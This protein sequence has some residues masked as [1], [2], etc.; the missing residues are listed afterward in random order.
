[1]YHGAEDY[2]FSSQ[3]E[4]TKITGITSARVPAWCLNVVRIYKIG[5]FVTRLA[6]PAS[7]QGS[8]ARRNRLLE[9]NTSLNI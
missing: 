4:E 7:T 8:G 2:Y 6:D 9:Q 3:S 5:V 1:M